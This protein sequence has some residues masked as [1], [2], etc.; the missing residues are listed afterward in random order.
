[1]QLQAQ[2]DNI[3]RARAYKSRNKRPCDFCRYKKAACHLDSQ[4]PCELCIR[5]NKECTFV[6]SPAKR[7]RPNDSN[8]GS[9]DAG[10][11]GTFEPAHHMNGGQVSPTFVNGGSMDLQHEIM[12]WDNGISS[13]SMPGM[14]MSALETDFGAFDPALYNNPT[15]PF[16]GFEP[17]SASSITAET[18]GRQAPPVHRSSIATTP[19]SQVS[20]KLLP[21]RFSK[22]SPPD[23][24]IASC[25]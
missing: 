19:G 18:I 17:V 2:Q 15:I 20:N 16:E 23:W 11:N 10:K 14:G 7:R 3:D 4:P 13:F 1:M 8:G 9:M 22:R 12:G 6:E 25:P 5:Y 21:K 24:P